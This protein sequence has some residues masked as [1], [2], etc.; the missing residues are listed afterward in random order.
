[1]LVSG[2]EQYEAYQ[3]TA[4]KSVPGL[5][6]FAVWLW[7]LGVVITVILGL[8]AFVFAVVLGVSLPGLLRNVPGG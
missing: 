3:P 1:M 5:V 8:L 4:W 7:A 2:Y 6:R